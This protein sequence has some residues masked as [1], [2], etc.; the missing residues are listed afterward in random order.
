MSAELTQE[1]IVTKLLTSNEIIVKN[2]VNHFITT[3]LNLGEYLNN[4]PTVT[5]DFV[6]RTPNSKYSFIR[7]GGW[8]F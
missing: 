1:E 8:N 3:P 4:L 2:K 5:E 6:N 7:K